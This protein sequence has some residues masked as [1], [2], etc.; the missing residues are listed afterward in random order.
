VKL[1]VALTVYSA[2]LDA[3]VCVCL[4]HTEKS[5]HFISVPKHHNTDGGGSV[6]AELHGVKGERGAQ[7]VFTDMTKSKILDSSTPL[8]HQYI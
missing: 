3:K 1:A 8:L 6:Q 4:Q 7:Q 5:V 2:L